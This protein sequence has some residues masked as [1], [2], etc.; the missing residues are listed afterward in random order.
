MMQQ[1]HLDPEYF[2]QKIL[3]FW[4]SLLIHRN[5]RSEKNVRINPVTYAPIW[6]IQKAET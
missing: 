4:N 1:N 5:L 2:W 6:S 3:E